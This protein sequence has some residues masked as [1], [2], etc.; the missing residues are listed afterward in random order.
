MNEI[1]VIPKDQNYE[2]VALGKL[3]EL[4]YNIITCEPE[5]KDPTVAANQGMGVQLSP[6]MKKDG[7]NI[8]QVQ[9]VNNYKITSIAINSL[10]LIDEIV[11]H[12]IVNKVESKQITPDNNNDDH[13]HNQIT[14][15]HVIQVIEWLADKNYDLKFFDRLMR[16]LYAK[17]IVD[18]T[19]STIKA[20]KILGVSQSQSS[21][22]KR[23]VE[24]AINVV[25]GKI[26]KLPATKKVEVEKINKV[27][28][29]VEDCDEEESW[30]VG[31][32]GK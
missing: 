2:I 15:E 14:M 16:G 9:N 29:D 19:G 23:E 20:A 17:E 31:D 24:D 7:V 6:N 1:Q 4:M 18:R 21:K 12:T 8:I 11:Q 3:K 26:K 32:S 10:R 25:S 28:E 5:T 27:V 30:T 13:N 22:L